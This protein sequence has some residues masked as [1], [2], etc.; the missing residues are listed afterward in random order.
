MLYETLAWDQKTQ[1]SWKG[2]DG[3][4]VRANSNQN[5]AGVA[6]STSDEIDFKSKPVIRTKKNTI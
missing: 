6:L 1:I 2:E 3:K 4:I 5:R